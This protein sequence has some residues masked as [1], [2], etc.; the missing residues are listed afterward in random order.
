ME[1][2]GFISASFLE[3]IDGQLR[4]VENQL[5]NKTGSRNLR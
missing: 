5:D 4:K 1:D 3:S 2:F